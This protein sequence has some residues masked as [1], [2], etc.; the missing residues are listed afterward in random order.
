MRYTPAAELERRIERFQSMLRQK[1]LDGAL[2]LQNADL[3]YFSGTI[4]RSHLYIP[5][6]GKALLMVKRN[7]ERARQESALAQIVPLDNPKEL[8]AMLTAYGF[9]V[10]ARLGLELDVLPVVH[11]QRYQKL[12]AAS[13]LEDASSLIR[14]ARAVKTD[15][16]LERLAEAA[17]LN[18]IVF[19]NVPRWLRAGM[20]EVELA[21]E[22][23][24]CFRRHG[25]QGLTRTR[26]FN[27]DI[28]YGHTLSGAN[29]SVPSFFEGPIGGVGLNPSF[30]MG[31][32]AKVIER[33]EPVMVDQ[34]GV[35]DGYGVDQSRVFCMGRLPAQL[36]RAHQVALEILAGLREKARPGVTGGEL[37]DFALQKAKDYGLADHFM[38][39]KEKVAFVGHGVGI[40][41]DELPVLAKG[42]A[43]PLE[44]GMVFA[45]EPKFVFPEGA[46]GIEDTLVVRA[47][48]LETITRFD[49]GIIYLP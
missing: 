25:H 48:G 1:G 37:F 22:V 40:E 20:T 13:R 28:S 35:I 33:D 31:S 45:L 30:A 41:L 24:A 42:V 4:Q 14:S 19:G 21:A 49:E 39:H 43:M 29:L 17:D 8:P 6:E 15:F 44:E 18:G 2:I 10:P 27:M 32:G 5:A 46:V 47:G 16:E 12:F 9:G 23:E 7:L 38:G 11:F 36:E 34:V 26:G 3:F